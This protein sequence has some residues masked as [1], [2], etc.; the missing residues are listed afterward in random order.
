MSVGCRNGGS[1]VATIRGTRPTTVKL[2]A[3][4]AEPAGLVAPIGP[5]VAPAGTW[6]AKRVVSADTTPANVTCVS[7]SNRSPVIVTRVPAGPRAGSTLVM[8][9]GNRTVKVRTAGVGSSLPARSRALT[10]KV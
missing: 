10:S 2:W 1:T 9:G 6:T 3:L 8:L 7:G 4:V 5:D